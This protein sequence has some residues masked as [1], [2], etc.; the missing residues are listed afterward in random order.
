MFQGGSK[1]VCRGWVI[2]F[3][4]P[5]LDRTHAIYDCEFKGAWFWGEV[6]FLGN[7][8]LYGEAHFEEA[9]FEKDVV[10]T[11]SI[12]HRPAHF[13]RARFM[14][15]AIFHRTQFMTD[16]SFEGTRFRSKADF[17]LG[18]FGP[19]GNSGFR[20]DFER[21][22]F[23]ADADFSDRLFVADINLRKARFAGQALTPI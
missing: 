16:A 17:R 4:F 2:P 21:T 3:D 11:D 14:Q 6:S 18:K 10:F 12:F 8:Q 5:T 19:P 22:Q 23:E 20:V 1:Y 15:E 13:D 9:I 7:Q